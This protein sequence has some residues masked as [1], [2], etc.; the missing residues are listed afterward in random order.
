M[1]TSLPPLNCLLAF[2]AVARRLSFTTAGAELH[3]TPSA[4]S[5]QIAKLEAFLGVRLFER[6]ARN[7]ELTPA[8]ED[9]IRRV[10]VALATLGAATDDA[11]KGVRNTLHVH[12]TPSF[13]SL[14]LMPR[15]AGFARAHPGIALSLSSSAQHSDFSAG[16]VDLD[17]RYGL[18]TWPQLKVEALFDEKI[19][20]LASPGFIRRHRIR[21]PDDLMHVPLIQSMVGIVQWVD[22]FGARGSDFVPAG[23]AYRFDRAFMALDAAVQ[24]LGVALESTS[25]GA[26]Y[27]RDRRL[28]PVFDDDAS[29]MPVQAHFLVY[30]A[31]H[32]QRAA[33][34][35]FVDWVRLEAARTG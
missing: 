2:E 29:A 35:H 18:P 12:A 1:R 17:V 26:P 28:R 16:L 3:L 8:G 6:T 5:H 10:G 23:F 11:R 22:W 24:G 19:T 7:V 21:T 31:R 25:I 30:P 13:A 27:L 34:A 32:A 15:L 14:W 33:L 20:P 4:I 9:Y